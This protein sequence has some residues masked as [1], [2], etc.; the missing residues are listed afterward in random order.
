MRWAAFVLWFSAAGLLAQWKLEQWEELPAPAAGLTV[1]KAQVSSPS[2]TARVAGV[3]FDEKKFRL[4]VAD[5]PGPEPLKL[6]EAASRSGALAGINASY[7]HEDRRPLGLV[8]SDGQKLHGQERAA[9]LSG[10]LAVQ[11]RRL[12]LVRPAAFFAEGVSQAIQA[13]PWLVEGGQAVPGLEETKLA[14]R[15]VVATDGEGRWSLLAFSAVSL[16]DASRILKIA[17]VVPG[18]R[19]RDALNLDGGSSTAF[20]AATGNQQPLS[21]PEFGFVRNFL[22]LEQA[23]GA[24]GK[25]NP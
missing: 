16:A 13:G 10:I 2:L 24:G 5:N 12:S 18:W 19:V 7:F 4:R 9:L 23:G 21:I 11:G 17:G 8:I 20:W 3:A 1:W 15:T 6:A 14:R 25:K 22:L